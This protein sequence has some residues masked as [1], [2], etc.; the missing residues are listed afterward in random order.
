MHGS[1]WIALGNLS[2]AIIHGEKMARRFFAWRWSWAVPSSN[3]ATSG[4]MTPLVTDWMLSRSKRGTVWIEPTV[5]NLK[6]TY[7]I[8]S[9]GDAPPTAGGNSA[10][11]IFTNDP[12]LFNTFG[13]K[14]KA[15]SLRPTMLAMVGQHKGQRIFLPPVEDHVVRALDRANLDLPDV[16]LPERALGFRVQAY[17]V[18]SYSDLFLPRQAR[19]LATFSDLVREIHADV[20]EDARRAGL[21]PSPTPMEEGGRG[22]RAYADA[23]TAILG[24][25]IGRLATSNNVLVQ[26]FIDPR[27]G[28]GKATPAFRMQT[29]SMVWD[30]VETN[31]FAQSVGGWCGPVVESALNAFKLV[32]KDGLPAS[33]FQSDAREIAAHIPDGC[34]IATDPPYYANIGYADLSDFFYI[35][36][37]RSLKESF[38]RTFATLVA[39][40]T[41]ELIAAPYRHNDNEAA[42]NEYFRFGFRDIFRALAERAGDSYPISI[43]YAIKQKEEK[44]GRGLTGWEVFLA[45]VL[46]AGLSVVATWPIR[47]TTWTRSRGLKSNALAS[48]ICVVCRPRAAHATRASKRNSS[49]R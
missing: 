25:C 41:N 37:R 12:I 31:P 43:T 32:A 5:S 13:P 34:L 10:R 39:P 45:G 26:W 2:N 46:D 8:K 4:A 3:P 17:G 30:F 49:M 9:K 18:T 48:A 27:S 19:T 20:L 28:T 14:G 16:P 23:V 42:A 35:W 33:V 1:L 11:C 15:G 44:N 24:L 47:T 6:I 36:L 38:P 21:D 29:V 7:S 22:A 40:K